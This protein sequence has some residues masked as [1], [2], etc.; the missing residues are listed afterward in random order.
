M[1]LYQ[2]HI[3]YE[4]Y[5]YDKYIEEY[6]CDK[7]K[8]N[9]PFMYTKSLKMKYIDSL[10]ECTFK[11]KIESID[12]YCCNC[13]K[14]MYYLDRRYLLQKFSI[15]F[16]CFKEV[17]L[18]YNT[19]KIMNIFHSYGM[20]GITDIDLTDIKYTIIGALWNV[21]YIHNFEDCINHPAH[22]DRNTMNTY[23]KSV[24]GLQSYYDKH[25]L[26]PLHKFVTCVNNYTN[27][28]IWI[29]HRNLYTL[30][31]K[32]CVSI[33]YRHKPFK[34][35]NELLQKQVSKD[36]INRTYKRYG[37]IEKLHFNTMDEYFNYV[38]KSIEEFK[39]EDDFATLT[40]INNNSFNK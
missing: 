22:R 24:N 39:K 7:Q 18:L 23:I 33:W 27:Q 14:E 15:C 16:P 21:S 9:S 19:R 20:L 36:S 34:K 8:L 3:I 40:Y 1:G 11:R 6:I 5:E 37:K 10:T 30:E 4:Y 28:V 2:S 17:L 35:T 12:S 29:V 38:N 32:L 26:L 13:K 31:I 25:P